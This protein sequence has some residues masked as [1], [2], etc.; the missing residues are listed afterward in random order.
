MRLIVSAWLSFLVMV[1]AQAYDPLKISRKGAGEV[2]DLTVGDEKRVRDLPIR[3]Y[4]PGSGKPAPVVIFSHG[5]GGSRENSP[6]LGK[7]WSARGYVVVF[8][9]HAGS[10]EAVW[11]GVRPMEIPGVMK[12][13]ASAKNLVLRAEDVPAVLDRLQEWNG[14]AGHVLKGRLDMK[15][16]G[17]SGHSFGAVTTQAVSGQEMRW[18]GRKYTD[19]RIDAALAMSPSAPA[20]G[21]VKQAFGAVRMP[22]LL[23]TGTKDVAKLG[24]ATLGADEVA[25]RLAVYPALPPGNKYELVLK[26][27]EHGA[28]G[29]RALAG[30]RTKRNPQHHRA[31]LAISTAFWDAYLKG[32][33]EAKAWLQ[34]DKVREVLEKEDRWQKK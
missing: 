14:Q 3:V 2:L 33:L 7:H 18:G 26:D 21:D 22:W 23:M 6:Y 20:A 8:V 27:A 13:A 9:Q 4:L 10:D 17:M 11:K 34:G 19:P 32:D 15:K 24:R 12:R 30:E 29:E 31:I 28:F 1:G 25:A 16:V 5:L